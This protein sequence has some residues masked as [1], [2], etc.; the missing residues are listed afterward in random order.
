MSPHSAAALV[1]SASHV[2]EHRPVGPF[3]DQCNV[4]MFL[5]QKI[6]GSFP[7]SLGGKIED[8]K[9]VNFVVLCP[10]DQTFLAQ[11]KCEILESRLLDHLDL[12]GVGSV[13]E[14]GLEFRVI[15]CGMGGTE[16]EQ[17]PTGHQHQLDGF[18]QKAKSDPKTLYVVVVEGAHLISRVSDLLPPVKHSDTG[19]HIENKSLLSLHQNCVMLYVSSHPYA[20]QTNRSLVTPANEIHWPQN[21]THKQSVGEQTTYCSSDDYRSPANEY[22]VLYRE[23]SSFEE[24]FQQTCSSQV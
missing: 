3:Q 4:A 6:L 8:F 17:K 23:D 18:I 10:P 14:G 16:S 1:P 9:R 11:M 19:S 7:G 20:L 13:T 22:R 5:M 2:I 24:L 15:P 21:G 12:N